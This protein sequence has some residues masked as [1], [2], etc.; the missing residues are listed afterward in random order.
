MLTLKH[1]A[2]RA[3]VAILAASAAM[4]TAVNTFAHAQSAPG[5]TQATA[6][7]YKNVRDF[8]K[9][10]VDFAQR[11]AVETSTA[12]ELIKLDRILNTLAV[13]KTDYKTTAKSKSNMQGVQ[14]LRIAQAYS[15]ILE[16]QLVSGELSGVRHFKPVFETIERCQKEVE[17]LQNHKIT[18]DHVELSQIFE[19]YYKLIKPLE[20]AKEILADFDSLYQAY[21]KLNPPPA[22]A[23]ESQVDEAEYKAAIQAVEAMLSH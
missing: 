4:T 8:C 2:K 6:L 14:E 18:V 21:L 12:S 10:S 15:T 7:N 5:I 20:E 11:Q 1:Q 13:F 16:L 3:I 23:T 17:R 22:G 19:P 9:G